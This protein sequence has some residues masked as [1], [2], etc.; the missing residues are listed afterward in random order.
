[1]NVN[2]DEIV[3][4]HC[5]QQGILLTINIISNKSNKYIVFFFLLHVLLMISIWIF[6]Y[7][8]IYYV[9]RNLNH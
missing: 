2:V 9:G 1:M 6:V 7:S 3:Y 4:V 5:H 8:L